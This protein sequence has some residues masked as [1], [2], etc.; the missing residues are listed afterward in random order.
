ML[1]K[2]ARLD[3]YQGGHACFQGGDVSFEGSDA[4]IEL[5]R[6]SRIK[7]KGDGSGFEIASSR[8]RDCISS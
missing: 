7:E 1:G 6:K 8:E 2:K 3:W 5:G 4:L